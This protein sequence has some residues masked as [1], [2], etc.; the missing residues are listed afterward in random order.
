MGTITAIRNKMGIGTEGK[1]YWPPEG[2][3]QRIAAY[4]RYKE[5][6]FGNHVSVFGKDAGTKTYVC[7]NL[8]KNIVT[9][10]SDL[11]FGEDFEVS[12]ADGSPLPDSV[13]EIIRRNKLVS[14]LHEASL[15]TA[16]CGDGVFIVSRGED[17]LSYVGAQSPDSWFPIL[18]MDNQ[19]KVMGHRFAWVREV[20]ERLFLRM[21]IHY[22]GTIEERLFVLDDAGV[23][24]REATLEEW[25]LLYPDRQEGYSVIATDVPEPLV[26]HCPNYRTAGEYFGIS[27]YEGLESLFDALNARLT[28]IDRILTKHSDPMLGLPA[29]TYRSL[30]EAATDWSG[31]ASSGNRIDKAR[32]DVYMMGEEGQKA[33][34]VTWDAQLATNLEFTNAI[35]KHIA[36]VSETAPQLI[37]LEQMGGGLSG[38]ALR[39]LLLRTLAKVGRRRRY[40]ES[41]IK[42]IIRLCLLVEGEEPIDVEIH[43]PDG[44]PQDALEDNQIMEMRLSNGTIDRKTAIQRLDGVD[45]DTA[46]RLVEEINADTDVTRNDS[47]LAEAINS[48]NKSVVDNATGQPGISVTVGD[49]SGV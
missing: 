31:F 43:W 47:G 35:A 26:V 1:I 12:T 25:S 20:G 27:E 3:T 15:D 22:P 11:L 41:A 9:V 14:M 40:Y 36:S 2:D 24:E 46:A 19:K 29:D 39:I 32:L 30:K 37:G 33:E 48:K 44:L 8:A 5:L 16:Y 45:E 6:F 18:D 49:L 17:G 10:V 42:D 34:Y 21:T 7:A 4:R 28:Q 38:R 13:M 23:I